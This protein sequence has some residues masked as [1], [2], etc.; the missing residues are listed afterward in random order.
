MS[1]DCIHTGEATA[2]TGS[3]TAPGFKLSWELYFQVQVL[4]LFVRG[5]T[6]QDA[7]EAQFPS[8]FLFH[9]L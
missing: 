2:N 7:E 9:S 1:G 8:W 3:R 6:P 4:T 5:S